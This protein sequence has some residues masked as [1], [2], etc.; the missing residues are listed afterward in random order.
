MCAVACRFG[1]AETGGL[2]ITHRFLRGMQQSAPRILWL[3]NCA[4][5][6]RRLDNPKSE[7]ESAAAWEKLLKNDLSRTVSNFSPELQRELA[8]MSTGSRAVAT[9]AQWWKMQFTFDANPRAMWIWI[10]D[11]GSIAAPPPL[12]RSASLNSMFHGTSNAAPDV[13]IHGSE[14]G[15]PSN[16]FDARCL[17]LTRDVATRAVALPDDQ[18]YA[19]I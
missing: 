4:E 13:Q 16:S 11:G 9:V 15:G 17:A 2:V 6:R 10:T 3:V 12:A 18:M 14:I 5:F 1:P 7:A 8:V 19:P